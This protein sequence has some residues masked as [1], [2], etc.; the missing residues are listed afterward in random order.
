LGKLPVAN[1]AMLA[2]VAVGG[3]AALGTLAG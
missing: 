3:A 2:E 1:S